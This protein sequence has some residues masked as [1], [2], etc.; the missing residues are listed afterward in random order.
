MARPAAC[1][2]DLDGLLLDTEPLHGQAWQAA[3]RHFGGELS[4]QE[5]LQLQGQ[6][7]RENAARVCELLPQ[8][9]SIEAL[10]AVRQPIAEQLLATAQPLPGAR[11][12]V[13]RCHHNGIPMALATSSGSDSVAIKTA[14]HAWLERISVRVTGDDPELKAGKPAPDVFLL[15]AARLGVAAEQ[16]WAFEDSLAGAMAAVAAGCRVFVCPGAGGG[17]LSFPSRASMLQSLLEVPW[18]LSS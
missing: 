14:P 17:Q 1:L 6:R 4:E 8:P 11:E 13:E 5:L 3:A 16:C 18:P 7:R 12:L 9:V 15:A 10:L 2:F